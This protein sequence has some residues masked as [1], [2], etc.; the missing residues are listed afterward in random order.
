VKAVIEFNRYKGMKRVD[1]L[2]SKS[3]SCIKDLNDFCRISEDARRHLDK[4]NVHRLI[5]LRVNTI[6]AFGHVHHFQELV[7]ETAHQPVKRGMQKPNHRDKHVF[8]VGACLE[9]DWESTLS[10]K[11]ET[12]RK[13]YTIGIR[14][15]SY[16]LSEFF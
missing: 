14:G 10:M 16:K 4:Q 7:F 1:V 3:R 9:S 8:S 12:A 5:V 2:Y 13:K 11:V 6:A 15:A